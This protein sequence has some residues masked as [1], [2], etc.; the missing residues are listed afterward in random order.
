MNSPYGNEITG[1]ALMAPGNYTVTLT[2]VGNP[3]HGQDPDSA[4]YGVPDGARHV[5]SLAEASRECADYIKDN[6]L[7]GGNWDGGDVFL[8]GKIVARISYNGR[9]WAV[10]AAE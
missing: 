9:V 1:D 5:R 3:D 10:W 2:S 6:Q 7:G 4:V 8:D